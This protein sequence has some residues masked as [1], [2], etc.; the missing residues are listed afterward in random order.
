MTKL[1]KLQYSLFSCWLGG[2]F[3]ILLGTITTE[4]VAGLSQKSQLEH[5]RG[6]VLLKLATVRARLEGSINSTLHLTRGLIAY[7]ATHPDVD[8]DEFE[9]LAG[10]IISVG[11]DIRNIGLARDNII[12]HIYPFAGNEAALGIEYEKIPEQWS[13]IERAIAQK[14]TIVA[15]PVDLAQGGQGL[16]A[17]TPIY[18]RRGLGGSLDDAPPIYWGLASIVIDI[19]TLF[20]TS[21][22]QSE[23]STLQLAIR[24]K[25]GLGREGEIFFGEKQVFSADPII[26]PVLL[27]NG[28]WQIAAVPS[29]GWSANIQTFWP[30]RATGY[31]LTLLFSLLITFLLHA[32]RTNKIL[33]MHDT[34]TGL[35]NR[36]LLDDRFSQMIA[37]SIRSKT[38]F[39]LLYIDLNG[40]KEINDRHGHKI[41]DKLL[42]EVATRL[43]LNMRASDTAA[44]IV[45]DEFVVLAEWISSEMAL[46]RLAEKIQQTLCEDITIDNHSVKLR[47]SV[48]SSLYPLEGE[49]FDSLLSF[50]DQKMY[51]SKKEY[52][53]KTLNSN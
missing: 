26:M 6:D 10:E 2:L 53:Q 18:T 50:A 8:D 3:A 14:R 32:R 31:T 27:P 19:P 36:R 17:R 1:R 39:G 41:G 30:Y 44:R 5:Q 38:S 21:G 34:L 42:K 33:A 37:A 40:F 28:S 4:F 49:D 13:A 20:A 29:R 47:S 51:Q 35:P 9:I 48:G 15:G 16:I 22:I 46:N 52:Y 43:E 25:D 45:G 12:T 23:N 24:G 7:V 11:R